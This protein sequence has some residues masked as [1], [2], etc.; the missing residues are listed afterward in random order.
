MFYLF[1][2]F[3][4]NFT[5]IF[6]FFFIVFNYFFYVLYYLLFGIYKLEENQEGRFLFFTRPEPYYNLSNADYQGSNDIS[7]GTTVGEAGKANPLNHK[8]FGLFYTL[9]FKT[10]GNFVLNTINYEFYYFFLEYFFTC[11]IRVFF[12]FFFYFFY[13]FFK[14]LFNLILK[15]EIFYIYFFFFF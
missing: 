14:G 15:S 1:F 9:F 4:E 13:F 10:K 5:L 7:F 3:I 2:I 11:L 8:F 6:R 12:L